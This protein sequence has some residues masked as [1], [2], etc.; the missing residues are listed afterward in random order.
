MAQIRIKRIE[1]EQVEGETVDSRTH[2]F[3]SWT[4]V[5]NHAAQAAR[6][7]P[8]D[9]TYY[10]CDVVAEWQDGSRRYIRFDMTREH[11]GQ[12]TP[13]SNEFRREIQFYGGAWHPDHMTDAEYTA[14]LHSFEEDVIAQAVQLLAGYDL[15]AA[16]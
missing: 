9:G 12:S 13:V 7:A 11:A 1:F 2:A 14:F 5:D 8:A 16:A 3:F 4:D 10:K 6:K 15:G